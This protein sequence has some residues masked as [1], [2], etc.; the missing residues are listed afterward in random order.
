MAL[1]QATV[2]SKSL[3]RN[4][5]L[6]IILPVDKLMATGKQ[7]FPTLYLLHGIYGNT[8]DWVVN[9]RINRWAMEKDLCVVMP[10][11]ENSFYLDDP[12][13]F[14]LWSQFVGQE[15][16]EL[17]RRMFPL[18]QKREE[19]FLGGLSMGGY[20][21]LYNGLKYQ[22]TFGRILAFS[23]F[24]RMDRLKNSSYESGFILSSRSFAERCFGDLETLPE[25]DRNPMWQ[26][27]Q[28][29][30]HGLALPEIYLACGDRDEL[31]QGSRQMAEVLEGLQAAYQFD[32][33][34]GAHE[35]D[36]WDRALE[37]ALNWLPLGRRRK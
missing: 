34:P 31:I 23:P 16:V 22:E 1:L 2:F 36:L 32:V 13:H 12:A 4:V 19:T 14:D 30:K 35:W 11:G 15:L 10:S 3:M 25:S 20:G 17:T 18:S 24:L 26:A 9:T 6:T 28:M 21:A 33:L 7:A 37:Q 8:M 29:V 5:P 27:A